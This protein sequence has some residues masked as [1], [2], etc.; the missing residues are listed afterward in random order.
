MKVSFDSSANSPLSSLQVSH[1]DSA[2]SITLNNDKK[3][4]TED[5]SSNNNKE[6]TTGSHTSDNSSLAKRMDGMQVSPKGKAK[7][8]KK[9]EKTN[10]RS[11]QW[12]AAF[13]FMVYY[14]QDNNDNKL[15]TIEVHLPSASI[16]N[17]FHLEL[18]ESNN[19]KQHL[20]V[21]YRVGGTFLLKSH[22]MTLLMTV[23]AMVEMLLLCCKQDTTKFYH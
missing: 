1:H 15:C 12:E 18:E 14:W 21:H 4:V 20:V 13:L 17:D 5:N 3:T 6:K 2:G 7:L 22:L 11:K 19:D 10:N 9:S 16:L 23:M 8:K